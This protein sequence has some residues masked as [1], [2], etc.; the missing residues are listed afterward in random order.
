MAGS[1]GGGPEGRQYRT[2]WFVSAHGDHLFME[3]V[4]DGDPPVPVATGR[5]QFQTLDSPNT[6][7]ILGKTVFT[8]LTRVVCAMAETITGKLTE[9]W[10]AAKRAVSSAPPNDAYLPWDAEGVEVVKPDETEKALEIAATMNKMQNTTLTIATHVKTQGLGTFEEPGKSYD[11]AARYANEPVFLQP[12]QEPDP[13][14]L[15]MKVFGVKGERLE[16]FD[17]SATTQDFFF[18][19]APM[20]ELTDIDTCLDVMEM[21]EKYFDSPTK[22]SAAT[23]LRIDA[24]KQ[25]APAML[26]NT[27]LISHSFFSQSAFRFGEYYGH[28][29]LFPVFDEMTSKASEKVKSDSGHEALSEWLTDYFQ[30]D[31]A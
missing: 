8:L 14:G 16:D 20:I 17:P 9:G 28:M 26:P 10:N 11:V 1:C 29:G 7:G 5:E 21:R 22:L 19:N 2:P 3:N 18:N 31:G 4:A 27:N 24:V 30:H 15:S 13:R 6:C 25:N 23:K 12:D